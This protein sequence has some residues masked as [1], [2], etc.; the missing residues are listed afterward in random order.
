[1]CFVQGV[2]AEQ[3]PVIGRALVGFV[4]SPSC[5]AVKNYGR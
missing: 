4:H 3:M 2:P 5:H 1:M